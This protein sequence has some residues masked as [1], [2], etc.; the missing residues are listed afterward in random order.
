MALARLASAAELAAAASWHGAAA[1][2]GQATRILGYLGDH[3]LLL[4]SM[5]LRDYLVLKVELEGTSGEG[6][7]QV[8][9]ERRLSGVVG[10]QAG[11]GDAGP[12]ARSG[13]RVWRGCPAVQAAVA[14][15]HTGTPAPTPLMP[16]PP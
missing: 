5:N 7:V 6:S 16:E 13:G 15:R 8:G 4:T 12:V 10:D 1:R 3:L 11:R 9:G 14:A 2:L